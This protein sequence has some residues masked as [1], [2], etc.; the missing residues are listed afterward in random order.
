MTK[1]NTGMWRLVLNTWTIKAFSM[2]LGEYNSFCVFSGKE[3]HVTYTR[4]TRLHADQDFHFHQVSNIQ[5][6]TKCMLC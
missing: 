4:L 6:L 5:V 2:C 3:Y 1:E